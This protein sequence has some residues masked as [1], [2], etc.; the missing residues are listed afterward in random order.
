MLRPHNAQKRGVSDLEVVRA[1]IFRTHN[2]KPRHQH[3]RKQRSYCHWQGLCHPVDC[4]YQYHIGTA[5]LLHIHSI[6][7]SL[8]LCNIHDHIHSNINYKCT[9]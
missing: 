1:Q 9:L 6:T 2:I 8:K 7:H 4:H 3:D 5:C